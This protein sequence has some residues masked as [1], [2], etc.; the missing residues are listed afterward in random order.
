MVMKKTVPSMSFTINRIDEMNR[1][2]MLFNLYSVLLLNYSCDN[3]QKKEYKGY[4]TNG[5]LSYQYKTTD[6]GLID[7]RLVEF[8]LTGDTSKIT[9]YKKGKIDGLYKSFY[10]NGRIYEEGE[11]VD[12]IFHGMRYEYYDNGQLYIEEVVDSA[13]IVEYREYDTSGILKEKLGNCSKF[14]YK[15]ARI[16]VDFDGS[17]NFCVGEWK[18][19]KVSIYDTKESA[20]LWCVHPIVSKNGSIK[21]GNEIGVFYIKYEKPSENEKILIV[22]RIDRSTKRIFQKKVPVRI[23]ECSKNN[24]R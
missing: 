2:L 9:T 14:D 15:N 5:K 19:I 17:T 8:Y 13:M 1:I 6:G 21:Y 20:F 18:R 7:G 4:Y 12:G 10:Q 3:N 23:T 16:V 22:N 11:Y 24:F